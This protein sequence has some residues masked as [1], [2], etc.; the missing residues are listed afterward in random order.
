LHGLGATQDSFFDSYGKEFPRLAEDRGYIVAAPLGY[1]VDGAY[2]KVLFGNPGD[3]L[4]ARKLEFS[5]KDVMSVLA[6]M[7]KNYKIDEARIYLTGH[8]MGAMGTWYLGAKYPEIW[9]ALAPFSGSANPSTVAAMKRIPEI[10]VHGEADPTVPV[11]ASR[12]MVAEMK[13][14]GVEHV[15]I[16]V[17]GGNHIN[18]VAPNFAAVFDFFDKHRKKAS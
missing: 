4:V 11:L 12:M 16:E 7:R 9:A 5:E 14:Q 1:R 3:P 15:Y 18:V 13:K 6:L 8:S 10:V 2:G 17:P